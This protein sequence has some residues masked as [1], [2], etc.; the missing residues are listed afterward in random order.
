MN[1]DSGYTLIELIVVM[2]VLGSVLFLSVP[3]FRSM[4]LADPAKETSRW[5]IAMVSALRENAVSDQKRYSLTVDIDD[6]RL[7]AGPVSPSEEPAAPAKKREY[8]APEGVRIL[9]VEF[10]FKGKITTGKADIFFYPRGYSDKALIHLEN[11]AREQL[12]L[13]VE[14]FLSRVIFYDRHVEFEN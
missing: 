14:P 7:Q 8:R 12:T 9:D 1:Q 11:D 5:I 6:N 2:A 3:R 10:P 4:V 13:L